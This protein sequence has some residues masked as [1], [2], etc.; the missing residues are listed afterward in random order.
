MKFKDCAFIAE[1]V[2]DGAEDS[3]LSAEFTATAAIIGN[4]TDDPE[5][6]PEDDDS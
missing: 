3:T 1:A 5:L 2:T 6:L 4:S